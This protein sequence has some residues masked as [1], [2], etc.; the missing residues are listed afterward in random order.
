VSSLIDRVQEAIR[1]EEGIIIQ[2]VNS[3]R[4][5]AAYEE[6]NPVPAK[7]GQEVGVEVVVNFRNSRQLLNFESIGARDVTISVD[8]SRKGFIVTTET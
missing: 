3:G 8:R 7:V 5:L 2:L 1:T 6:I 4:T